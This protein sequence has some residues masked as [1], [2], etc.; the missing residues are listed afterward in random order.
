[1]TITRGAAR[2][3]S[4]FSIWRS[5][6]RCA[7]IP[8]PNVGIRAAARYWTLKIWMLT[9]VNR[10][11]TERS[12]YARV[13]ADWCSLIRSRSWTTTAVWK[14][15][16][17]TTARCKGKL[18]A[19]IRSWRNKLWNRLKERNHFWLNCRLFITSFRWQRWSIRRNSLNTAPGL[20]R[21]P[22]VSLHR[23]R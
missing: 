19:W 20:T 10:V 2:R 6:R 23:V 18:S 5:T 8:L 3:S 4:N 1:M 12:G 15:S 22:R 9:C 17:R 11:I 16:K 7:I 21:C 14:P 13:D